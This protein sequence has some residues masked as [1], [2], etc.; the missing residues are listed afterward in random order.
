MFASKIS[1]IFLLLASPAI[2]MA[3]ETIIPLIYDTTVNTQQTQITIHGTGFGTREPKVSFGTAQ[4]TVTAHSDTSITATIP[5][6]T[7]AGAYL[8]TVQNGSTFL[9]ALF[10]ATIGQVGPAGPA[11]I[12][13]PAG[14]PGAPGQAGPAGSAGPAGPP[15]T[16]GPTGPPGSVGPTGPP[17]SAGPTGPPG[18]AGP[19]GPAGP[20]GPTGSPGP[21]GPTGPAGP[22]GGGVSAATYIASF[23]NPGQGAGTTFFAPPTF[24]SNGTNISDNTAI[25][26]SSQANFL[27]SP[28]ACTV[29]ALNV[30]VNNY[31]TPGSDTTKITVYK[32]MAATTMTCSVSTDGNAGGCTDS[33]HTFTVVQGDSLALGFVETN[34]TPANMVT[35]G[36]VCQ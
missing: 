26:S 25:A 5:A 6:A 10:T 34:S 4:L 11:G 3:Q 30:G 16:A 2:L 13:G 17:G 19:A 36:L 33:T 24:P 8:L 1:L 32:N 35:I 7:P 21:A 28:I 29:S 22:A 9:A 23:T 31:N 18:S 14:P 12:P 15:G 20:S 27:S